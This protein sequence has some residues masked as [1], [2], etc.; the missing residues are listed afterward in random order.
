MNEKVVKLERISVSLSPK[1][2]RLIRA[3]MERRSRKGARHQTV[4]EIAE[5]AIEFHCQAL[6]TRWIETA[7]G[8]WIEVKE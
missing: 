5:Q 7:D 1:V 8:R 3:E 2:S 6:A 4:E